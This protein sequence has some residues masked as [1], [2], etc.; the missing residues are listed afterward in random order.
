[1]GLQEIKE[2]ST[3]EYNVKPGDLAALVLPPSWPCLHFV[4]L[5]WCC[6]IKFPH[7]KMKTHLASFS[8]TQRFHIHMEIT[9][10]IL[11]DV[12]KNSLH[13][14]K[15]IFLS[16]SCKENGS[17]AFSIVTYRY[18]STFNNRSTGLQKAS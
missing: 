6:Q 14:T 9:V 13:H 16:G 17:L 8:N 4:L 11:P 2:K 18:C 3:L 7:Q 15:D 12:C 10:D 5:N 1:M